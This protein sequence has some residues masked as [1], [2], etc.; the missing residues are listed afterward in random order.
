MPRNGDRRHVGL[1]R[2]A[3]RA[4]H[5]GVLHAGAHDAAEG[6]ALQ[7]EPEARARRRPRPAAA[8]RG[9]ADR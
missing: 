1:E 8:A 2:D 3:E 9:S 4:D 6:G 7:Q 5:V